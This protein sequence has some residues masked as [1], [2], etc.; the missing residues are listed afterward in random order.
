MNEYVAGSGIYKLY[1]DE[2]PEDA[3]FLRDPHTEVEENW[4]GAG[5]E[6]GPPPLLHICEKELDKDIDTPMWFLITSRVR[7]DSYHGY[8]KCEGCKEI[9]DRNNIPGLRAIWSDGLGTG[10]EGLA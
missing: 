1:V 3:W 2:L 10:Y 4:L 5:K 6:P 7:W 9:W 8:Y